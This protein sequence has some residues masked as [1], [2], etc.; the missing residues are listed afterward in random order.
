MGSTLSQLIRDTRQSHEQAQACVYHQ[1]T[2]FS[3]VSQRVK[4]NQKERPPFCG[5]VLTHTQY[6]LGISCNEHI[7]P[8]SKERT[9]L[10]GGERQTGPNSTIWTTV[11]GTK[12]AKPH[13]NDPLLRGAGGL[14]DC[15]DCSMVVCPEP[16]SVN[17]GDCFERRCEKSERS[18]LLCS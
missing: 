5:S 10:I 3:L 2:L 17:D 15:Q 12:R 7:S 8:F 18:G 16:C 11:R 1:C 14:E 6:N 9:G 4:G 13:G